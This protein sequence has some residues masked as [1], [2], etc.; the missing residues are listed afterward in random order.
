MTVDLIARQLVA[1]ANITADVTTQAA[2]AVE[3]VQEERLLEEG[4]VPCPGCVA[5]PSERLSSCAPHETY[6]GRLR[7]G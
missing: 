7:A 5:D 6:Y 1:L 3:Q 4:G 2:Q